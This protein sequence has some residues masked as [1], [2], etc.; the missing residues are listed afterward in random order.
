MGGLRARQLSLVLLILALLSSWYVSAPASW[1][2]WSDSCVQRVV[3]F[4]NELFW[5]SR[6]VVLRLF[7]LLF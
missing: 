5:W 6:R 1:P 2:A 3:A 7:I 4:T